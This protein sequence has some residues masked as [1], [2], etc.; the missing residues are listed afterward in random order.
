MC[1]TAFSWKTGRIE[2]RIHNPHYY[3]YLRTQGTVPRE[4]GDI[5]C[6]RELGVTLSQDLIEIIEKIRKYDNNPMRKEYTELI[7]N[8]TNIVR[9][10]IHIREVEIQRL[11]NYEERHS[12]LRVQYL[13]G[14]KTENELK[15]QLQMDDKKVQKTT[16]KNNVY[17]L[18]VTTVTDILYRYREHLQ[19][20][21]NNLIISVH[22]NSKNKYKELELEYNARNYEELK[23]EEVFNEINNIV[24][25]A[26]EQFKDI[27][28]SYG[29][30]KGNVKS[31]RKNCGIYYGV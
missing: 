5:E 23:L 4:R 18:V 21:L 31:L 13:M 19:N 28:R 20:V 12:E 14:Y 27:A 2:N 25:Y 1:K 9:N 3:E 6:G 15:K 17:E 7:K 11:P 26:N 22:D 29:D 16:D 24:E 8:V 30:P 10:V